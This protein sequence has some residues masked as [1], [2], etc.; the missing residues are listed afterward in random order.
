MY[1]KLATKELFCSDLVLIFIFILCVYMFLPACIS[2]CCVHASCLWRPDEGIR[3]PGHEVSN[4][5]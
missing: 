5:C 1:K 2:V 4:G 3:S